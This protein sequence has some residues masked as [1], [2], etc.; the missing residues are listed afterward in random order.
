[1]KIVKLFSYGV[2]SAVLLA[3]SIKLIMT[4]CVLLAG[5]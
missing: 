5:N 4:I 3:M 1:M 2:A